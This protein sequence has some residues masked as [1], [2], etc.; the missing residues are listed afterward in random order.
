M[1]SSGGAPTPSEDIMK[2]IRKLSLKERIDRYSKK[3][4]NGCIEYTGYIEPTG[5]GSIR[6]KKQ[7]YKAH[8]ASWIAHNGEI[9][10]GLLVLHTC[11][12]PKCINIDHLWLGTQKENQEDMTRKGRGRFGE[13]NGRAILTE[14]QVRDIRANASNPIIT[15]AYL[16]EY[17]GIS[18]GCLDGILYGNKWKHI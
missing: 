6:F 13:K 18:L 7:R 1:I 2:G 11:D 5:Y 14:Q 17:Y 3:R 15:R 9:P 8:R 10:D 4:S 12:N 16:A